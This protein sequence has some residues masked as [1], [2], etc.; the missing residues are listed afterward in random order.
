VA[1][2]RALADEGAIERSVVTAAIRDLELDPDKEN[3]VKC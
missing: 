2:L 3:P 1:A